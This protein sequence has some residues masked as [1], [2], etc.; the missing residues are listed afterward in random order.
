MKNVKYF[1][2]MMKILKYFYDSEIKKKELT[3]G[4]GALDVTLFWNLFI[5]SCS[6]STFS[7]MSS[8]SG[9]GGGR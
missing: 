2:M 3:L 8:F 5:R 1:F 6:V 4:G 9:G 7:G